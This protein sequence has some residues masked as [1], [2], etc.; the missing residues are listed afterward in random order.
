M[1]ILISI[2]DQVKDITYSTQIG[3]QARFLLETSF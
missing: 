1:K 2:G 3:R